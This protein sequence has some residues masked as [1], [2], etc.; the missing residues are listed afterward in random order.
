MILC[1]AC[2]GCEQSAPKE[3]LEKDATTA[4]E[5]PAPVKNTAKKPISKPE[6]VA[7]AVEKHADTRAAAPAESA[8]PQTEVVVDKAPA[9]GAGILT[10]DPLDSPI[11]LCPSSR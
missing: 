5:H 3:N 8:K 11:R 7:P 6:P 4:G 1:V 9:A 2:A 10:A